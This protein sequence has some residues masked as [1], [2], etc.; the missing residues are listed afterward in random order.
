ML[1][2]LGASLCRTV[3][4]SERLE[5]KLTCL[6]NNIK[7]IVVENARRKFAVAVSFAL[8]PSESGEDGGGWCAAVRLLEHLRDQICLVRMVEGRDTELEL[9]AQLS[10]SVSDSRE[11][12]DE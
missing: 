11:R 8:V 10:D 6:H 1:I 9:V 2:G 3:S 12:S 7:I 5:Q 4:A